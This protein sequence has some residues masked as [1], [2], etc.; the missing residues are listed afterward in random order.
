MQVRPEH[1]RP[2]SLK[3]GRAF[4]LIEIL[5]VMVIVGILMAVAFLSFGILGN[6]DNMDREARRLS[7]LIQLVTDEATTQGRD[8]GVEFMTVGYRFVEHDPLLDQWFEVIGDDYLVQRT[9]EEGMEFELTLEERRILLHTEAQ[10]TARE[11]VEEEEPLLVNRLENRDLT[12]DY[13]PHVLILSSGDV[14]PFELRMIRDADRRELLL[15]LSLAGELEILQDD[16][17]VF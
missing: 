1:R 8:F 3:H 4:T 7:S 12:D 14:T 6:D 13:L 11:E 9:L 10:E 17:V 15:T 5:V 2:P 16:D